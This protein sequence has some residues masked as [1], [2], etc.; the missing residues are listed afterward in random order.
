[1]SCPTSG[2]KVGI[3]TTID[4]SVFAI[5]AWASSA[6]MNERSH[7]IDGLAQDCGISSAMAMEIATALCWAMNMTSLEHVELSLFIG[8]DEIYMLHNMIHDSMARW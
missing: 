8:D 2:N 4:F 5:Y 3:L 1:M 7:Y 6:N